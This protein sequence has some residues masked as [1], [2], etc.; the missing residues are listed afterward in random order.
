M[1]YPSE[2]KP[3]KINIMNDKMWE[4]VAKELSRKSIHMKS[5]IDE[6]LKRHKDEFLSSSCGISILMLLLYHGVF[7]I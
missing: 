7:S 2:I 6:K 3:K 5:A 1:S 4:A